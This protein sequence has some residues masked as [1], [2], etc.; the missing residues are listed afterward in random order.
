M[1]YGNEFT[2]ASSNSWQIWRL[3][4]WLKKWKPR[5]ENSETILIRNQINGIIILK[6]NF[7]KAYQKFPVFWKFTMQSYTEDHPL[8]PQMQVDCNKK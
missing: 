2:L 8:N 6:T 3:H 7:K 1:T 4:T 5:V